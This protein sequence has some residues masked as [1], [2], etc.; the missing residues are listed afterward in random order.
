MNIPT[1]KK[2]NMWIGAAMHYYGRVQFYI[3]TISFPMLAATFY[4]T[5]LST[6]VSIPWPILIMISFVL[7]GCVV[8]LDYLY[9]TPGNIAYSNK[10]G[11]IQNPIFEEVQ[12]LR[13]DFENYRNEVKNK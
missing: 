8:V 11:V 2:G 10:L 13:K 3:G 1:Q 9:V 4:H 7:F 12:A 6:Y 5:T